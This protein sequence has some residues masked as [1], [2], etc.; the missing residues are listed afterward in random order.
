MLVNLGKG[1]SFIGH[2]ISGILNTIS[3]SKLGY[4]II[5]HFD[6]KLKSPEN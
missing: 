1:I 3:T 2:G 6:N 4:N 5:N